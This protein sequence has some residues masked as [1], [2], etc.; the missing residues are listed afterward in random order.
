MAASVGKLGRKFH[1]QTGREFFTRCV[2][3]LR[4]SP[5]EAGRA[6]LCGL[7]GHYVV[8]SLCH[9]YIRELHERGIAD[10]LALESEFDRQLLVLDGKRPEF[11]QAMSRHMRL[12]PGECQTVAAFYPPA[13][14]G[15]IQKCVKNMAFWTVQLG[16]PAG[17][18]RRAL[19]KG[20]AIAA[21]EK[22]GMLARLERDRASAPYVPALMVR[23]EEAERRFPEM[24][25]RLLAHLSHG[26]DLGP[27]FDETFG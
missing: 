18:G 1:G 13:K 8:D 20:M 11:A 22:L 23:Y 19:E 5:S 17:P 3:M 6:Y 14:D 4:L 24:L 27:D 9:P 2:R 15:H 10:H 21:P 12:T 25:A 16:Q 26:E 7:L